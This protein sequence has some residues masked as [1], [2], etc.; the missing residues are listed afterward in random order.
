M[1]QS[2]PSTIILEATQA[3][4]RLISWR[5]QQHQGGTETPPSWLLPSLE[6]N[7]SHLAKLFKTLSTQEAI[8]VTLA[9]CPHI[10]SLFLDGVI[11]KNLQKSGSFPPMAGVRGKQ[12]LG[13]LPT[14][15]TAQFILGGSDIAKRF[16]I[17][18]LLGS[19]QR[20]YKKHILWLDDPLPGEPRMSG[21][22]LLSPDYVELLT[23]GKVSTPKFSTEF[24]ARQIETQLEWKDLILPGDVK[25]QILDLQNWIHHNQTLLTEWDM[26]KRLKPGFRALFY[27]PPGTGKTMTASLLGKYTQRDVFRIDLSTVVS[28]YIGETEKNLASLFDKAEDKNW[29]L[30]FDEADSLFGKRTGVRDA[31][32]KYANQEVSYLLQRIEE[33]NGLVILASNFKSNIDE[34]FMRRF[35]AIIKFPL[36]NRSEREIIWRQAIPIKLEAAIGNLL[37]GFI[38]KASKYELSGGNIINVVHFASL[39]YLASKENKQLWSFFEEGIKREFEKEGRVFSN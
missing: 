4:E 21:K 18:E 14:G 30:F 17:Q 3:L 5:I 39:K 19:E 10:H 24:P 28:K 16:E 35:N 9:L 27:G 37:Q 31:H 29:I 7:N 13:F 22:L 15:E 36:P 25:Q 32:D 8:I 26:A 20:L 38:K 11:S 23:T 12:F 34:A 1:H 6:Q 33:F 2:T